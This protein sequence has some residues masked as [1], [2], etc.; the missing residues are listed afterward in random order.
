MKKK[1]NKCRD[2]IKI[3]FL[4]LNHLFPSISKINSIFK[5]TELNKMLI[6]VFIFYMHF[7]IAYQL[8]FQLKEKKKF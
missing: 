8:D 4:E 1:E 6:L 2:D 3:V 5:F 7:K